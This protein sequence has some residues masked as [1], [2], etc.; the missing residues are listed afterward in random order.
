MVDGNDNSHACGGGGGLSIAA[1][2]GAAVE[3]FWRT[4]Q[5]CHRNI[6]LVLFLFYIWEMSADRESRRSAVD[7]VATR[8]RNVGPR[9]FFFFP[10]QAL[11]HL[12]TMIMI[13]ISTGV[14]A[15]I[16][17]DGNNNSHACRGGGGGLSIAS[18]VGAPEEGFW[19]TVS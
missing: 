10:R 2:V 16:M 9:P 5:W 11:T 4:V 15:A 17:L 6:I 12:T 7:Q 18:A 13:L 3:S 19:C 1:A 8:H 14:H